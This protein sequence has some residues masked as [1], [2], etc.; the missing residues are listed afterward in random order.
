MLRHR[1]SE[2]EAAAVAGF[3]MAER[4]DYRQ[5]L[6]ETAA[7]A[8]GPTA[9]AAAPTTPP[10]TSEDEADENLHVITASMVGTFYRRPDPD[11]EPY[12]KEGDV[13]KKGQVICIL[14]AMK[15]HNEIESDA[16]GTVVKIFPED[17]HPVEYGEKLVAIR[18]L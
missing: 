14:E 7:P 2:D 4:A 6:G 9:P 15:I 13:I 16:A 12:V 18:P 10:P 3:S 1:Y 17:S 11:T 5:R 8:P